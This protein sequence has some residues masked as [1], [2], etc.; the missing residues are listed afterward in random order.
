MAGIW[1]INSTYNV[2]TK[3]IMN[4]LSFEMGQVFKARIIDVDELTNEV[5][6]KLLD[7]WQ[8]QAKIQNEAKTL[9]E[10]L[11]K[12]KVEGFEDGK[13]KIKILNT[14][15]KDTNL[16][17]NNIIKKLEEQNI[18]ISK[19][20]YKILDKMIKH[21]MPLT[22]DNI[23]MVKSII[24]FKNKIE[25]EPQ[26]IETFINKFLVSKEVDRSEYSNTEIYYL[27]K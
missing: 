19:D 12:F 6:L 27:I 21:S 25:N 14:E 2:N 22:R 5:I 16:K 18:N 7:G 8:F 1:N 20:D 10:G 23:S 3:K 9:P 17:D 24:D 15:E 26:E 4:N 11:L 13:L